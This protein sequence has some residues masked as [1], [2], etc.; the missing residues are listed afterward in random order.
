MQIIDNLTIIVFAV[1]ILLAVLSVFS[2]TF[3]RKVPE[4][5]ADDNTDR[6]PVSVI[7]ISENNAHELA[8]NLSMF[9]SQ[10]YPAGYE[11]IVVVCKDEDGTR[12][13]L[14]GFD[15]SKNLYVTFVPESSRYVSR[16]KLAVTLGVKAAKNE[17]ILLT[18]ASCRPCSDKWIYS[19]ASQCRDD[20]KMI[21][22]YSN[23]ADE[24]RA[25]Q[26]FNRLH[27]E[28]AMMYDA[29]KNKPYAMAGNNLMFRKSLFMSGDGF[30]DN[31]KY[32][33]G[34]YSFIL[35]K[36]AEKDTVV[37]NTLPEAFVEEMAPTKKEWHDNKLMYQE[38]RR[39][40]KRRFFH[41]F[42]FNVDV[43]SL[44]LCFLSALCFS[45]Y[46]VLSGR[47]LIFQFALSTIF[48]PLISRIFNAKPVIRRFNVNISLWCVIPFEF[49]TLWHNLKFII[50]HKFS[51]EYEFISHK[52]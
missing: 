26:R 13:V 23:Y 43:L 42:I 2:D 3:L 52:I 20:V 28:Y 47:Y 37:V 16:R 48:L 12:D 25:F 45:V 29:I 51:D 9:L 38:T 50:R 33:R 18:D 17:W 32:L 1:L 4:I 22:G 46:G 11:V 24:A 21:Y 10:D 31:L 34:E 35:N 7:L 40:L 6:K 30:R 41:R 44:Y 49:Y 14:K 39:H 19:M 27:R 36:Y 5:R 15:N 8:K